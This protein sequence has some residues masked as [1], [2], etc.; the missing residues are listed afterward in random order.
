MPVA[1]SALF[2]AEEHRIVTQANSLENPP[3]IVIVGGGFGGAYC[4]Q[5][6]E[7]LLRPGEAD[8][9]LLDRNNYFIFYPLLVE[10]GTGSL[11]PRH[12][13]VSIRAFLDRTKY[14]MADVVTV[15]HDRREV[16]ARLPD[17]HQQLRIEY[18]HLVLT[19]GSVTRLPDVAG[20]KEH[21]FEIKSLA[22]AVQ[23]RDHAIRQLERADAI[24]DQQLRRQLLHIVVVGANFTGVE[25]AGEFQ[26]FLQ[27]AARRFAN[28]QRDDIK[29]T[30]VEIGPRILPALDSDLA[31]YATERMMRRG[32]VVR[33]GTSVDRVEAD[34]AV[35]SDGT[36][37]AT[38]TVIWCAG[39]APSPLVERLGVPVD[40]RG[41]ILCD[42]EL[43]VQ[44]S[45]HV[46]AIGDSAVNPDPEG[47]PYPAT[48]QH[49]VQQGQYLARN[50]VRVLRDRPPL[51][52]DIRSKGAL[53][54][55]GCRT[56][57]AKVFGF[58]VSGFPAWFLWRTVYLM[59]MP[60]LARRLRI[61]LDWTMDLMFPKDIVQLGLSREAPAREFRSTAETP[62]A[63][64]HPNTT[65]S[66]APDAATTG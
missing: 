65:S 48:A 18:D 5:K 50:L 39:I 40:D 27:R 66:D 53:A 25:V 49:A 56:G 22:D 64:Q 10:A 29:V 54:A 28:V 14:V 2:T 34:R 20:L 11:E 63:L 36:A 26:V 32:M 31:E 57:V 51:P 30:L 23:L 21:G 13:V 60:G 47:R 17:A 59:K 19:P 41:Y 1:G 16:V 58:K 6:L 33:L 38:E 8:V 37:L 52:C 7:G 24:D 9:V 55:L 45:D 44:G 43:R 12:A 42:R 4:A 35:L 62:A 15:D 61:A 3:R 46:W